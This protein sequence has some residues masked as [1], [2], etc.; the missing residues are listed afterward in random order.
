MREGNNFAFPYFYSEFHCPIC[1]APNFI[2]LFIQSQIYIIL[3]VNIFC[4]NFLDK[5][6]SDIFSE[7]LHWGLPFSEFLKMKPL[8]FIAQK[9]LLLMAPSELG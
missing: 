1:L 9:S 7:I 3:Q 8:V 5:L 2:H 4:Y 6:T